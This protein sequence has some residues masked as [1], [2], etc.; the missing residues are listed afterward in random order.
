MRK[1]LAV[2]TVAAAM[3]IAVVASPA[4]AD[5]SFTQSDGIYRIPHDDGSSVTIFNDHHDHGPAKDRIDMGAGTG[6]PLVAAASGWIRAVVDFN[7]ESPGAG[8]GVDINGA[9]QDDAAEHSCTNNPDDVVGSCSNYNNYVWIEHPNGE[10]SKY[11]HVGTGT[12]SANWAV[13]DW[14]NTGE[15]IGVEGDIGAATGPHLHWEVGIPSD[16]NDSTPFSTLGGFLQGTNVVPRICD[17]PDNLSQS[18]ES[19]TAN[20]CAN[21]A[22]IAD[23]GG[24]YEVDEGSDVQFDGTGSNDPDGNPLTYAW[25]PDANL[26]DSTLAQPTYSGVDD[27]IG[28]PVALTVYDQVEALDDSDSTIVTVLNVSPTVAANGDSIDEG[29]TATV[30]A[31]FTDPGVLD[32]H[33]ATIDWD[34]G[35]APQPVAVDQDPGSGS[36][37]ASHVYGDNGIYNVTVTVTDDDGG[38]GTDTVAVIAANLDPQLALDTGDAVSFPGGDYFVGRI[39]EPQNHA[40]SAQDPGSDDLTFT[41]GFGLATTYFNDGVALDPPKSPDGVFPFFAADNADVSFGLPGA[42]IIDVAVTDDDGGSEAES[43]GK[44]VT[45]DADTTEGNGWWKHQYSSGGNPQLEDAVLLGYLDIVNAVSS[46]FSEATDVDTLDAVHGTLSPS[47]DDRRVHAEADLMAAWL[48]FAS[49]AVAW[50]AWVPLGDGA[51]MAFL[52]L[53]HQ[54]ETTIL[55]G[56]AT[57]GALLEAEHLAQRVRH[58]G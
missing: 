42:Y 43:L 52:D 55:D 9:S 10:W 46:V 47:G 21:Q 32:T 1:R 31:T 29:G 53:M 7:G 5:H 48:H 38:V 27:V 56:A 36:A 6:T 20:P 35:T 13:G 44:I 45:G 15:V 58:A 50:D 19:H 17:I 57:D 49:G 34:D 16:P 37:E 3:G 25:A 54:V 8:D 28:D 22:P 26:D 51:T 18:G 12:A 14:I 11:S 2:L 4:A 41:W 39:G 40:A 24:P 33:T 30:T 23:A